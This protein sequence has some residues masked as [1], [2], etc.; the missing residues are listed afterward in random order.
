M[1]VSA[2]LA[3]SLSGS[4]LEAKCSE[5][6]LRREP[7]SLKI[8]LEKLPLKT[9][10]FLIDF[11]SEKAPKSIPVGFFRGPFSVLGALGPQNV[12][13]RPLGSFFRTFSRISVFLLIFSMF[14]FV[15]WRSLRKSTQVL[16]TYF[17]VSS[18]CFSYFFYVFVLPQNSL[19]KSTQVLFGLLLVFRTISSSAMS[20]LPHVPCGAFRFRLAASG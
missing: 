18:V 11:G 19:R 10:V 6:N 12:P 1:K 9:I 20:D 16:T 2:V 8:A 4:L 13:N 3:C 15:S 5:N 7:E 14:F 17:H